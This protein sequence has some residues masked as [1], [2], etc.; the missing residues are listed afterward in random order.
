MQG[1]RSWREE[2]R[3]DASENLDTD[4]SRR[5]RERKR[6]RPGKGGGEPLEMRESL[7]L[8]IT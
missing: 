6:S 3:D 8:D 4:T 7:N 2:H 1:G 5:L